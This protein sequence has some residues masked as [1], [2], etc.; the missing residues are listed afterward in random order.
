V[1]HQNQYGFIQHR[2][3]HDCLAWSF[4]FLHLCHTSKKEM[5]ILKLD[6]KKAFDKVEHELIL[7]VLKHK[8]FP[9]RWICWI[10][11]ILK[12]GTSTALLNGTP[13]KVFHCR[14][15]VR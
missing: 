3:I 11:D 12:S 1:V 2:S 15:G 13:R 9:E 4:E 8:G 6:F 10:R 14:R 7:Q 5:V